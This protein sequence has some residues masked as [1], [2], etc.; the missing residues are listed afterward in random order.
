MGFVKLN[1]MLTSAML[2]KDK[3]TLRL[4]RAV[5]TNVMLYKDC[6]DF[7]P[8]EYQIDKAIKREIKV[9]K[10]IIECTSNEDVV[11]DSE[12]AISKLSSWLPEPT[13]TDSLKNVT[14]EY[15]KEC[16]PNNTKK[17]DN[18]FKFLYIK[19]IL[20]DRKGLGGQVD[21]GELRE[22]IDSL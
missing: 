20:G 5:K 4:I 13:L 1:S 2:L 14:L 3:L 6:A 9:Y 21:S 16:P 10:E 8:N 22:F 17:P 12:L 19:G 7:I 11:I 18:I 15:L